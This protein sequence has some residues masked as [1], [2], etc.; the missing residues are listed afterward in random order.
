[1]SIF[2]VPHPSSGKH[3]TGRVLGRLANRRN[4]VVAAVGI[5][6]AS[7]WFGWP[8]LVVAGLAPLLLALALCLLMCGAMCAMKLCTTAKR[9]QQAVI[10]RSGVKSPRN[11]ATSQSGKSCATCN[12]P[13]SYKENSNVQDVE[14]RRRAPPRRH[15]RGLRLGEDGDAG[16]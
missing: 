11:A 1:M 6:A 13:R 3:G 14:R 5:G 9:P 10:E 12:C 2:F 16:A 15:V 4:L 8:W 7:L